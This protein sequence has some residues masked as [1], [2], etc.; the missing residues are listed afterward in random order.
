MDWVDSVLEAMGFGQVFRGWIATFH[1]EAAASF[2]LHGVSPVHAILFS[3]RQEDLLAALL[4]VIHLEP[5]LVWLEAVLTGLRV[6]NIRE[7]S[8]GY[9]DEVQVVGDDLQDIVKVDLASRDFEA[10]SG[11]LLN[12]I[13]KTT[14]IGLGSGAGRQ[15]WPLQWILASS[16]VKVLGFTTSPVV[17]LTVQLSRDCV[18]TGME[19]TLQS[20]STRRLETL[21]QRVQVLEVFILSKA[22]Y[23]AHLLPLATSASSPGLMVPATRLCSLVA[24]FLWAGCFQRMAFDECHEKRSAGGLGLSCPQTRAQAILAKQACRHLAAGVRPAL[25]LAYWLGISLQGLLLAP[26]SAGL[27]LEGY[28]PAQYVDLLSLLRK[29]FT[30]SCVDTANLQLATSAAIYKKLTCTFP[31]PLVSGSEGT[32]LGTHLAETAGSL[33]GGCG[34]RPPF[35]PPTRPPGCP[36]QQIPLGDGPLTCLPDLPASGSL[37]D[38]PPFLHQ[39]FQDLCILAPPSFSSGPPSPSEWPSLMR[40]SSTWRGHHWRPG[41]GRHH[42]HG[43]GH[44]VLS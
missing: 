38:H 23:I 30:L 37:R 44:Q 2:L 25:H 33:S 20:W 7:A 39:L 32:C 5:F 43:L 16:S 24:D 26:A 41:F 12:R 40:S 6:A 19:R 31:N 8:F 28:P 21:Q 10:A 13:C 34:G 29:V 18:L 17:S 4:F 14:I 11:A 42:L 1:R 35:L 22:W 15:N 3:I 36:G 9:M 27:R